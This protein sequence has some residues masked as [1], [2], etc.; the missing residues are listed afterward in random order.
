MHKRTSLN[1]EYVKTLFDASKDGDD[2]AS[3][4]RVNGGPE[5]QTLPTPTSVMHRLYRLGQAYGIRQLRY[6]E[7][8]VKIVVGSTEMGEFLKDLRGLLALVNDEVLHEYVGRLVQAIEAP[9]GTEGK[10]LAVSTG[11]YYERRA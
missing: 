8:E 5:S 6:L 3:Y 9:P 10:S 7:P 2:G 11:S 4:F 1:Y